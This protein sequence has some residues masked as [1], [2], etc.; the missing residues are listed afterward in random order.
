MQLCIE[1]HGVGK[2]YRKGKSV[3]EALRDFSLTIPRGARFALLGPNG[4]GKSSLIRILTGLSR[5]GSGEVSVCGLDPARHPVR[6]QEKIG[7]A[8]Q[9]NDLDPKT[10]ARDHLVLQARLFRFGRKEAVR[11]AEELIGLFGLEEIAKK[12]AGDL[13]GG[14]KRRLHCALALV[15]FPE[16]LFLDEPTVGM[17]PEARSLFWKT[18]REY[19][20]AEGMTLFLTT[21]YLDEADRHAESLAVLKGGQSLF[22]GSIGEFKALV[23]GT[24]QGSTLSGDGALEDHYLAFIGGTAS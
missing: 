4:A 18:L 12:K 14:Y 17:D 16:V 9:E 23:S 11:R 8:L 22:S 6:L 13:S 1:A 7:V 10:T 21:Q 2:R 15:H 24:E 19:G 20:R 3:T 5:P